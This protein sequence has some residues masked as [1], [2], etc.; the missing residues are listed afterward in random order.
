MKYVGRFADLRLNSNSERW[1][2][3]TFNQAPHKPLLL[4]TVIDMFAQ[5]Q[6]RSN[7]IKISSDMGKLFSSYWRLVIPAKGYGKGTYSLPFFHL[8][9]EKERFWHLVPRFGHDE[10]L[11]QAYRIAKVADSIRFSIEKLD[12]LILG[13]QL[14][15]EL[16][17]LFCGYSSRHTLQEVLINTYFAPDVRPSL[18]KQSEINLIAYHRAQEWFEQDPSKLTTSKASEYIAPQLPRIHNKGFFRGMPLRE[19]VNVNTQVRRLAYLPALLRLAARQN[20]STTILA[21]RLEAWGKERQ[22]DLRNYLNSTGSVVSQLKIKRPRL[23][24][25]RASHAAKRYV[26]FAQNAGWLTQIS[27]VYAISRVGRTLLIVDEVLT[28]HISEKERNAFK[29]SEAQ[30][31]FFIN[32]LW[33]KDGDVLF[34][35]LGQLDPHPVPLKKIQEDYSIAYN[36]HLTRRIRHSSA[37]QELSQLVQ[38][39]R[40]IKTWTNPG[41]YAEQFVA[42]R[43]NWMLDLGLVM[44]SSSARRECYLTPTGFQFKHSLPLLDAL[45]N[46]WLNSFF[47]KTIAHFL[48]DTDRQ[49]LIWN[50]SPEHRGLLLNWLRVAFHHFRRGPVPKFSLTQ[51]SLFVSIA[52]IIRNGVCLDHDDFLKAMSKPIPFDNNNVVEMRLSARENE[53]YLI[54]NPV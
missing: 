43:L 54:L 3:V 2:P 38:R 37:D 47:L 15:E 27:G 32:E 28:N 22:D 40:S 13:A 35:L 41:R 1:P 52:M 11:A 14:D 31:L 30:R 46:E 6:I 19:L 42:T 12:S 21:T 34:T 8:S 33:R 53:A 26:D 48:A 18:R 36:E 23:P 50:G 44:I 5:K 10:L 25:D 24:T 51:I 20:L 4:L 39:L 49:L 9:T 16:Y 17:Q 45:S 29:L 7:L